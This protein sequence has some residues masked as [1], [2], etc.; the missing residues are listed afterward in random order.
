MR[1]SRADHMITVHVHILHAQLAL[2][3]YGFIMCI[4]F[5][6]YIK[7]VKLAIERVD[8]HCIVL[9]SRCLGEEGLP[10]QSEGGKWTG[11]D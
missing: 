10:L 5:T 9:F 7:L 3:N 11:S 1:L 4:T 2:Y 6:R 8:M